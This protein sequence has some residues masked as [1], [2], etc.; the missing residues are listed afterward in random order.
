MILLHGLGMTNECMLDIAKY[1][2][3]E[4]NIYMFDYPTMAIT[5][6]DIYKEYLKPFLQKN[7]EKEFYAITHSMGALILRYAHK[8]FNLKENNLN[9]AFKINSAVMLSPPNKGSGIADIFFN[10]TKKHT[11]YTYPTFQ[12]KS[13]YDSFVYQLGF[14]NF[15]HGIIAGNNKGRFNLTSK[16]LK[17]DSDGIVEVENFKTPNYTDFYLC[18]KNDHATT[19]YDKEI[20]KLSKNFLNYSKFKKEEKIENHI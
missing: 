19:L 4:Y 13:H 20:F 15:K 8:Q 6:E 11:F 10:I 5:I 17:N 18:Q 14:C 12:M 3:N 2:K 7:K 16:I 1:F 9:S